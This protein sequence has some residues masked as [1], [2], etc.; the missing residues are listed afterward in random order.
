MSFRAKATKNF[1]STMFST[2]DVRMYSKYQL[3]GD[4]EDMWKRNLGYLV[5]CRS[6]NEII[7][8]KNIDDIFKVFMIRDVFG[9]FGSY[10]SIAEIRGGEEFVIGDSYP[11]S[12]SGMSDSGLQLEMYA[13]CPISPKRILLY[14]NNGVEDVPREVLS[15]R[16]CILNKPR[17]D[18]DGNIIIKVKKLYPEEIQ[19]INDSIIDA[20][21]EGFCRRK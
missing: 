3:D 11:V 15:F 12:V 20:A 10:L 7:N 13:I 14:V 18:I 4:F 21:Q 9:T 2:E 5:N 19:N 16:K 17:I 8:H 6:L 1:F